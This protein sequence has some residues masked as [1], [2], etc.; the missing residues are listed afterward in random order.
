VL[1]G[2]ASEGPFSLRVTSVIRPDGGRIVSMI[3]YRQCY[4]TNEFLEVS[5]FYADV[6]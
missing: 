2:L 3:L 6:T 1:L 4:Y 5:E